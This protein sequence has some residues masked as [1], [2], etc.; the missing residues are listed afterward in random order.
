MAAN[1]F[2]I[3]D[4]VILQA[5]FTNPDEVVTDPTVVKLRVK[6]PSDVLTVYTYAEAELTK[7]STGIYTKT[8]VPDEEGTWMYRWEGTGAVTAVGESEF[9]VRPSGFTEDDLSQV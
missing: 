5:T 8:V 9:Q 6:S 7:V 1:E 4:G 3:G 2:D